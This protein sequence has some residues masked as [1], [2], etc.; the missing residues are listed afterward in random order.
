MKQSI[1][2][3]PARAVCMIVAGAA[4]LLA[5]CAG[6]AGGPSGNAQVPQPARPVDL[7]RYVGR[8]YEFARYE[9][10]FER[11][12]DGVTADYAKREDGL[13]GVRNSCREG[14]PNGPVRSS[15]G[16]AKIVAG[17]GDAKL[18]VS[19]FGPFFFGDYWVLDHADD[20]AWSIVGE[21]SGRFL[22]ILTRSAKPSADEAA[23]LI[24][25]V[26]TLGYDT[27]MLRRTAH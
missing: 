1:V 7:D 22:W 13:I 16:R 25:R 17:S 15:E 2:R 26:R 27:K 5:G 10:R 12:C 21:P 23:A 24:E 4:L 9:N 19:F 8:W 14:G 11:G 6:L 3:R 20:Y 18:K